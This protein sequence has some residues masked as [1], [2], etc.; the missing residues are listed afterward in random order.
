MAL[1]DLELVHELLAHR[2]ERQRIDIE[3]RHLRAQHRIEFALTAG[4]R[5]ERGGAIAAARRRDHLTLVAEQIFGDVPAAIDLADIAGDVLAIAFR[6][7]HIV[8][9]GFAERAVAADQLDRLGRNALIRHVEQHEGDALI[10]VLLVGA[11]QAED[12]V[13]LVG[14]AGPDLLAVDDPMIA[15]VFAIGLHRDEVRPA[16]RLG[17]ALAPADFAPRDFVEEAPLLPFG[18]EMEQRRAEHPDAEARQ[19]RACPDAGHF[20]AQD[21]AFGRRQARAAIFLGPF[22]HGVTLIATRFEPRLLRIVFEAGVAAPPIDVFLVPHGLAHF[23]RAVG[24]EPVAHFG[25]EAFR[26]GHFRASLSFSTLRV[27][28]NVKSIRTPSARAI[29][30][31][32]HAVA[33]SGFD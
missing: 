10:L 21:L 16:A 15:L 12:P 24:F 32:R 6:H 33:S 14:I 17:I 11:D 26:I 8:H 31:S 22:G 3:H 13:R 7:L 20:L 4:R 27:D 18:P 23:G 5:T 1:I 30:P 28:V 9:K 19:R 25:A 2:G 29:A